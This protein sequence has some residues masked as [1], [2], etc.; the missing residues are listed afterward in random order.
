LGS[1]RE[2]D[3]R[4]SKEPRITY[5]YVCHMTN[6]TEQSVLSGDAGYRCK[7][8]FQ[9]T[10]YDVCKTDIF[11]VIRSKSDLFLYISKFLALIHQ[12]TERWYV[13]MLCRRRGRHQVLVEYY[14]S[15]CSRQ[16]LRPLLPPTEPTT[17][18]QT[19]AT[20]WHFYWTHSMGP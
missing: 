6:T 10:S 12:L 1:R 5:I 4:G 14:A 7:T 19:S 11:V 18:R 16:S 8:T 3:F 17:N 9:S 15:F 2:L 20:L 13:G